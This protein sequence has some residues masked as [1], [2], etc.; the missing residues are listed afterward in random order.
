MALVIAGEVAPMAPGA[1]EK[2]FVGRVWL[3]DDGRVE[4][5]TR[6]RDRKPTG[7]TNAPVVDVGD[8]VIHPGFIDLHSHIGYNSLP[9]WAHPGEA[10]PFLHRNIWPNRPTY[11]SHVA[12]PAWTLMEAAPE[13]MYAYAQVRAIAGGTTAIQGWPSASRPPTNRLVRSVDDD[14][15]GPLRDPISVSVQ[16]LDA[17]GLRKK[18]EDVLGTGRSFIYHLAEGQP[19]TIATNE[20]DD[21]SPDDPLTCLRPGFVAIHANALDAAAFQL[22]RTKAAPPSGTTAGTVVWSPLS[23]LWLYGRTTAVPDALDADLGVALGTDWGPS[24]TKNLLGEIKVARLWSDHEG[25]GLTD[26]QLVRMITAAPGDALA[27]AWQATVGRLVPGALADVAVL[28]RR[29]RN[30]WHNVVTAKDADVALVVVE[31]Q[32]R[33]GTQALMGAAGA[34]GTASVPVGSASR[35]VA[36]V[37]PDDPTRAWTWKDILTRL[38]AVRANAAVTPPRGPAGTRGAARPPR[39]PIAGDPPGTPPLG[40]RLDMP[41]GPGQGAGPPPKGRT[42]DV[43]PIEPLHHSRTWLASIKGRGFHGQ[44]LDDLA[45]FYR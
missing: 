5:V 35:R 10:V 21:L 11:K 28:T 32:A 4:A 45:A 39:A 16:G 29:H 22:W 15:I 34:T 8:S 3:T 38:D 2:S 17:A 26:A 1:E 44:V 33:F 20:I 30:V 31:G 25:W 14:Q 6:R 27:R 23:N 42:V 18:A 43:P 40:V 9:L 13:C 7:F 36:L 24:G 41:G 37:R 19:G 12:W